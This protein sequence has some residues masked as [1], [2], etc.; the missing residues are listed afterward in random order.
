MKEYW[1]P[2]VR[3]SGWK[4]IFPF[5]V[6]A[7]VILFAVCCVGLIWVFTNDL[8]MWWPSYILYGLSAYSLIALC[9]KLPGAVRME[10]NW[11]KN[12]PKVAG[13][14]KTRNYTSN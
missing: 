9:I 10:Q 5:P 1:N 6:R 2:F 14:L 13:L 8:D 11:L 4:K 12:H 3:W 7:A